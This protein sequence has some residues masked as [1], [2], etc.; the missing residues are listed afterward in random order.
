MIY[1]DLKTIA[2]RQ[3]ICFD[4]SQLKRNKVVLAEL[5][6]CG[7]FAIPVEGV[8]CGCIVIG[9]MLPKTELKGQSCPQKKW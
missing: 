8:S 5:Y 6:T 9:G 3:D 4:C 1:E 2:K 7:K